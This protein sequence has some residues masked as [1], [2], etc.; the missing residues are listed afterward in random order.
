MSSDNL[1][2]L[3]VYNVVKGQRKGIPGLETVGDKIMVSCYETLGYE[4]P[5]TLPKGG[6]LVTAGQ[7]NVTGQHTEAGI[8]TASFAF[9]SSDIS[10]FYA[11][12]HT[13]SAPHEG[14]QFHTSSLIT[15]KKYDASDYNPKPTYVTS[16][17]NLKSSYSP[18]ETSRFRVHIREKD[19]NP[20][21]YTKAKATP[22]TNIVE[23]AH[24]KVVRL[25]DDY[26]VLP[27]DT[28]SASGTLMSY[29]SQ[30]NYFDLEMSTLEPDYAYGFKLLLKV[31]GEWVQQ[32]EVHKFRVE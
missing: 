21:I 27:Y 1:N 28:G 17:T 15:V 26:V 2:K 31:N 25:S 18:I 9:T 12:W 30:G 29:D 22:D 6:G 14:R 20:T 10:S 23:T 24:F 32:E 8:Y 13:G 5:I 3:Y 11:V 16:I 19:W 4:R 7:Y